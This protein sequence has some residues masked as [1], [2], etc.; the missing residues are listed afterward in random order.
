[1]NFKKKAILGTI[2]LGLTFSMVNLCYTAAM[3][4]SA[5]LC[6][7]HGY[8]P[9]QFSLFFSIYNAG[10]VVCN[11]TISRSLRRFGI[12][13]GAI[14]AALAPLAGFTILALMDSILPAYLAAAFMGLLSQL[15]GM[16]VFSVYVNGWFTKGQSKMMSVG[17][18]FSS[19]VTIVASP[20]IATLVSKLGPK[21]A[22]LA[23]GGIITSV[24]GFAVLFLVGELPATYQ[25]QPIALEGKEKTAKVRKAPELTYDVQMPAGRALTLSP[26]LLVYFSIACYG[27]TAS[28]ISSNSV[29]I[30]QSYGLDYVT[31]SYLI[32]TMAVVSTI[33][34]PALG[35]L[36]DKIGIRG[37]VLVFMLLMGGGF[38]SAQLVGGM[39]G[40]L[41]QAV[42][43]GA[44]CFTSMYSGLVIPHLFGRSN[45]AQLIGWGST[46]QC[47]AG[48]AAP[49]LAM[50][51]VG[52]G[53]YRVV[54]ITGG[55]LC[56]LAACGTAVAL[57]KRSR[58][59]I[60][61]KDADYLANLHRETVS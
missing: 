15:G 12:K 20:T 6:Q 36:C 7:L 37:G 60:A 61:A 14:C 44:G 54:V 40:A 57:G 11:L 47:F 25:T 29:N 17:T 26:L 52:L 48:I 23:I 28:M 3:M 41:L 39:A 38:L 21:L 10:T 35:V 13:K 16:V 22:C 59:L 8:T 2:G 49:P 33:L 5:G 51:L 30:F 56:L 46:V 43:M 31:A 42:G 9:A 27:T 1:M 18:L 53:G 45:T 32:S 50:A 4:L 34:S 58:A 24:A 55:V 19:I